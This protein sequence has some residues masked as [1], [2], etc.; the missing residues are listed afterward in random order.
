MCGGQVQGQRAGSERGQVAT[1]VAAK[2]ALARHG[3]DRLL[4]VL[5]QHGTVRLE[6]DP[7]VIVQLLQ[8]DQVDLLLA[9]R[10]LLAAI[11][12][13]VLQ[14]AGVRTALVAPV[15]YLPADV[16]VAPQQLCTLLSERI[17]EEAA[18]A[19]LDRLLHCRQDPGVSAACAVCALRGNLMPQSLP[20]SPR[21]REVFACIARGMGTSGIATR[22]GLSVKTIEGYRERIKQKLGLE[23]R[24]A[25]RQAA[26]DWLA[27]HHLSLP[28][29][30]VM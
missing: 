22:T 24:E 13:P 9:D 28:A 27:G 6:N 7:A 5:G 19:L 18:L 10:D 29:S 17:S 26:A 15:D 8:D 21:E 3:L 25:L 12:R 1:V 23:G 16:G 2:G 30:S 11:P 20:L 4:H 14:A